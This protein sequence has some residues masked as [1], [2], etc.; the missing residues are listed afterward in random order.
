MNPN[1][2]TRKGAKVEEDSRYEASVGRTQIVCSGMGARCQFQYLIIFIKKIWS[3]NK[4][5]TF[6]LA[7]ENNGS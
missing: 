5:S 2:G 7:F 6:A 1:C 3:L 4:T